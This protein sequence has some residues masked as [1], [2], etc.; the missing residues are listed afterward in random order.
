MRFQ[1][2]N[3]GTIIDLATG[4]MWQK[5]DDGVTRTWYEAKEYASELNLAG[6]TDWRLPTIRELFGLTD[7][8]KFNPACDPIFGCRSYHYWSS[9]TYVYY[10]GRAWFVDFYGG[11]VF[12]DA[13]PGNYYVRC[14]RGK[15]KENV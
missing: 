1:D 3:N 12:E 15:R 11:H 10:P 14:V 2:N 8:E 5:D 4:L 13:K 9:S 7:M 6:H